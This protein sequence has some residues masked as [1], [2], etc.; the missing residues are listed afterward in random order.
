VLALLGALGAVVARGAAPAHAVPESALLRTP[1]FVVEE[2][3][4]GQAV[5]DLDRA[6]SGASAASLAT[7]HLLDSRGVRVAQRAAVR[8]VCEK[9]CGRPNEA[10]ACHIVGDYRFTGPSLERFALAFAG[11]ADLRPHRLVRTRL[12]GP[13]RLAFLAHTFGKPWRPAEKEYAAG[14]GRSPEGEWVEQS[15]VGPP[16][17]PRH[18][19]PVWTE[20]GV[21]LGDCSIASFGSLAEFDCSDRRTVYAGNRYLGMIDEFE[22]G[23]AVR[24][25]ADVNG[26]LAYVVILAQRGIVRPVL[27]LR[28]R[29]DWTVL[30]VRSHEDAC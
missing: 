10:E 25:S 16:A 7:L 18:V 26:T 11:T 22:L 4:E 5:V 20:T 17:R 19:L 30:S 14:W 27:V 23:P 15:T 12:E 1:V 24:Y 13:A 9:P 3:S 29:R 6:G 8:Q 28:G 2:G 21:E